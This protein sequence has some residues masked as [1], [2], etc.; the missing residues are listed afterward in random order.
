MGDI[1][2]WLVGGGTILIGVAT[3]LCTALAPLAILG[4]L[5]LFLYQRSRKVSAARQA[6]QHWL[7][8]VGTV[9]FSTVQVRRPVR[10]ISEIPAVAMY[11]NPTNPAEAVLEL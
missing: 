6:A 8:T 2:P 7:Q 3:A 5:G 4:S 1:F 9:F 10:S 11:Y